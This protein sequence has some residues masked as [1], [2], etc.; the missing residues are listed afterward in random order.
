MDI[1]IYIMWDLSFPWHKHIYQ[2][3]QMCTV[4]HS[5]PI[6]SHCFYFALV[7]HQYWYLQFYVHMID[8]V[9]NLEYRF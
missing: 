6:P 7:E 1:V 9:L 4:Q 3:V 8:N 2:D 5:G